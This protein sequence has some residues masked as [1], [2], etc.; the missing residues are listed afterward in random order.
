MFHDCRS[1]AVHRGSISTPCH[2]V[3]RRHVILPRYAVVTPV[4]VRYEVRTTKRSQSWN[5]I[6]SQ[7][8]CPFSSHHC[9][10]RYHSS[11]R[12]WR[13]IA[14]SPTD[15]TGDELVDLVI[16]STASAESAQ[17]L[18]LPLLMIE[19]RVEHRS[20]N[21]PVTDR[22]LPPSAEALRVHTCADIRDRS[23]KHNVTNKAR[24]Q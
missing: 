2:C 5:I 8:S 16:L 12:V 24:E 18:R 17:A 11:I 22:L 14:H 19:R 20:K 4:L 9:D 15:E 6:R 10:H 23:V 13:S 1:L 21:R 7:S 3:T